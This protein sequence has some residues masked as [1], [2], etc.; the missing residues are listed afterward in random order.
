MRITKTFT[1]K[2]HGYTS[3]SVA[4]TDDGKV[5]RWASNDRCVPLDA[6]KDYGIPID[7]VAQSAARNKETD[8]LLAAYRAMNS[9]PPSAEE[10]AEARAAHGRG[11][12]LVNIVTGRR[13]T[14]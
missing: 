5:W 7:L 12:E 10:I 3:S 6:A 11:V 13:F 14:T 4:Y 9:G 1:C 8:A 2:R